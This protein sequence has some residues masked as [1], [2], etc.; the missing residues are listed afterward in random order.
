MTTSGKANKNMEDLGVPQ[1]P[2]RLRIQC[3]HCCGSDHSCDV[4]SVPGQELPYAKGRYVP[5]RAPVWSS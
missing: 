5:P 1:W 3:C 2:S 4:G